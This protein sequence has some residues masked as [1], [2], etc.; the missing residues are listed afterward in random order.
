MNVVFIFLLTLPTLVYSFCY[1]NSSEIWIC[2]AL[3]STKTIKYDYLTVLNNQE[4]EQLYITNYILPILIINYYSLKLDILNVSHNEIQ[5]IIIISN[6]HFQ[7][8]LRQLIL[9]SNH[10]R[11]FNSDTILLPQSLEIISLANNQLEILDARVFSRLGNL[12]E[13]DLR[14]NQLKRILPKLLLHTNVHLNNNPLDCQCT[15]EFYRIVCENSTNLK[16]S[17]VRSNFPMNICFQ[18]LMEFILFD[19]FLL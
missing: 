15:P 4:C 8:N 1:S 11:Q 10:L 7:S 6:N 13:L 17:L 9:E 19:I 12:T 16:P 2:D 18:G 3:N 14:N 5:T